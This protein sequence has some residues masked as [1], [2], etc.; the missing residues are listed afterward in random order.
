[1]VA[2][3]AVRFLHGGA[4][5]R[6]VYL[7]L[8]LPNFALRYSSLVARLAQIGKHT[9]HLL[10]LLGLLLRVGNG[11]Q[12]LQHLLVDLFHDVCV[13]SAATYGLHA[14]DVLRGFGIAQVVL[15]DRLAHVFGMLAIHACP[16]A[17]AF[18][19]LRYLGRLRALEVTLGLLSSHIGW[20]HSRARPALESRRVCRL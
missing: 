4:R 7:R 8:D 17:R 15:L 20:M 6:A 11:A 10:K 3:C 1:M 13:T 19:R 16:L 18:L 14:V 12:V 2:R 5:L 9:L